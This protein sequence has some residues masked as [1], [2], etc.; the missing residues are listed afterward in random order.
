MVRGAISASSP[1]GRKRRSSSSPSAA[2][3][4][5]ARKPAPA[6][7]TVVERGTKR[8]PVPGRSSIVRPVPGVQ[9]ARQ[10]RA[11]AP[12]YRP[13]G[14]ASARATAG[15]GPG[16][17]HLE[18]LD[19]VESGR[20]DLVVRATREAPRR[21][22]V[23]RRLRG[24]AG[25]VAVA[26]HVP[27]ERVLPGLLTDHPAG[28]LD[29]PAGEEETTAAG[30]GPIALGFTGGTPV[31]ILHGEG[32][33]SEDEPI[34]VYALVRVVVGEIRLTR[35]AP[36]RRVDRRVGHDDAAACDES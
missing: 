25:I 3:G 20:V 21:G 29:D 19:G 1:G 4:S 12:F 2:W 17:Q 32:V 15:S 27:R 33:Q 6:P 23:R 26:L 18:V 16:P 10:N 8:L 34:N 24:A 28:L 13:G 5:A 7:R 30:P 22:E 36:P 9:M 35:A 14:H 31:V 11:E